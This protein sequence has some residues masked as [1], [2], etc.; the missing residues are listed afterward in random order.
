MLRL[1]NPIHTAKLFDSAGREVPEHTC[2]FEMRVYEDKYITAKEPQFGFTLKI[3]DDQS[4]LVWHKFYPNVL[5]KD[6]TLRL[7]R[8]ELKIP[9]VVGAP[10]RGVG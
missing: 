6:Q 9:L 1:G 8:Q 5:S 3:F 10:I 2:Q 7:P 4:Q